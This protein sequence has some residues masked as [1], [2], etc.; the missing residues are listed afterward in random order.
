MAAPAVASTASTTTQKNQY[1]QPMVKPAQGPRA[2]SACAEKEPEVGFAADIS[3]SMR[4][5]ST[6]SVPTSAYD[7]RMPGPVVAMPVLEPTKSPAP[8]TPPMAIIDRCRFFRPA[9]SPEPVGGPPGPLG[10][11]TG[12]IEGRLRRHVGSSFAPVERY[13]YERCTS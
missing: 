6:T 1:S 12:L 5:T 9:W 4:I 11:V 10:A 7:R 13:P 2:R 8:M 3:P